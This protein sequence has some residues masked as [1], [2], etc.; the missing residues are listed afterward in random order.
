MHFFKGL[1]GIL[2]LSGRSWQGVENEMLMMLF[3]HNIVRFENLI[4]LE[5]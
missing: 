5:V 3:A 2:H 1:E 4:E